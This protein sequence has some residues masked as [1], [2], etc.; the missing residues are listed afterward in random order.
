MSEGAKEVV[1]RFHELLQEDGA[2]LE[3]LGVDAGTLRVKY[4]LAA[5]DD[6]CEACVIRP[7]DLRGMI[8]EK[9]EQQAPSIKQVELVVVG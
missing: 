1:E 5:G 7:D 2:S 4:T 3:L 8:L 9:L 6:L